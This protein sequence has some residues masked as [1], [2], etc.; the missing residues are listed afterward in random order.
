MV[1]DT[2]RERMMK[3]MTSLLA[4]AS[5][6]ALTAC[7]GGGGS[8]GVKPVDPPVGPTDPNPTPTT[9]RWTTPLPGIAQIP[10]DRVQVPNNRM[11][12]MFAIS[13][14]TNNWHAGQ[15]TEGRV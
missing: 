10:L 3:R 13:E 7:G 6:V 9:P 5:M 12:D 1:F 4:A 11:K 15:G 8:S 2:Q 14:F